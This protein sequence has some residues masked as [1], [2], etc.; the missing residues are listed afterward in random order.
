MTRSDQHNDPR[1]AAGL[2]QLH[3]SG[4]NRLLPR[5]RWQVWLQAKPRL[6]DWPLTMLWAAIA[7]GL[8]SSLAFEVFHN[9]R[10]AKSGRQS[11]R[12]TE[13]NPLAGRNGIALAGSFRPKPSS[14]W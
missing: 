2:D 12:W 11:L 13:S 10:A 9:I 14:P 6:T 7:G 5:L 1:G 3:G 8:G 4:I